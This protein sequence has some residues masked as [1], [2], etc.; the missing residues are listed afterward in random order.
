ME[1]NFDLDR[2]SLKSSPVFGGIAGII[3]SEQVEP[4]DVGRA[5]S[6][7][8]KAT[9]D[10]GE[11]QDLY[12]RTLT[13]SWTSH[14]GD[15]PADECIED[16]FSGG[17]GWGKHKNPDD[18]VFLGPG[19]GEDDG[20]SDDGT[21]R[22]P[23]TGAASRK[24]M[25]SKRRGHARQKS[26]GRSDVRSPQIGSADGMTSSDQNQT[27]SS[28]SDDHRQR[29]HKRTN[30]YSE[31]ELQDDFRSWQIHPNPVLKEK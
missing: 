11:I 20:D 2:P 3:T 16:I 9:R 22:P 23:S 15:L 30:E 6:V 7:S 12:R 27:Q 28:S 25:Q 19:D 18:H 31:L 4:D 5:A 13:A 24:P 21:L 29:P 10:V 26:H 8:S 1:P 17:D 14:M